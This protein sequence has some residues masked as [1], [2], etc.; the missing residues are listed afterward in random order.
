MKALIRISTLAVT[1]VAASAASAES[2]YINAA[3][4][5]VTEFNFTALGGENVEDQNR[6]QECLGVRLEK[7]LG[8]PVNMRTAADYAGV[9]EGFLAAPW[10]CLSWA[11]PVTHA[12]S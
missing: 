12:S 3:D 11:L 7:V 9:L 10:T 6:R 5:G 2:Y 1:L 8:V 4:Y